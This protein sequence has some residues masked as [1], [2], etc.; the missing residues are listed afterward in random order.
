MF[1]DRLKLVRINVLYRDICPGE[2]RFFSIWKSIQ[3]KS[4]FFVFS[5]DSRRRVSVND[6]VYKKRKKFKSRTFRIKRRMTR[7][8]FTRYWVTAN[9]VTPRYIGNVMVLFT[10]A[11]VKSSNHTNER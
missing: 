2:I 6:T 4:G 3:I 5:N 1:N 9:S 10:S 7:T 8:R 11:A